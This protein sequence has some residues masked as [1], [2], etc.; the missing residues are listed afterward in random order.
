MLARHR[1]RGLIL[2]FAADGLEQAK[3]KSCRVGYLPVL[4]SNR[5]ALLGVSE[6]DLLRIGIMRERRSVWLYVVFNIH[7]ILHRLRFPGLRLLRLLRRPSV[8]RSP[9]GP[10]LEQAPPLRT[11]ARGFH[12]ES[13]LIFPG[14]RS[15]PLQLR[16]P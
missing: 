7:V 2:Q 6:Y 1:I 14:P 4:D 15:L 5:Q 11:A 10:V 12:L 8:A 3:G 13:A 16:E 9:G